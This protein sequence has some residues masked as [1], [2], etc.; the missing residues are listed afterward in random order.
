MAIKQNLLLLICLSIAGAAMLFAGEG[1]R[2]DGSATRPSEPRAGRDDR[3]AESLGWK[4]GLQAWTYRKLTLFETIDK[5]E[6]LGIRYLEMYPGQRL[7][8]E[9]D[10][11]AGHDMSSEHREAL[12]KKLKEADVT[13]VSYGVVG[14]S[15]DEKA[16][17]RVF[18]FAKEMGITTITSEPPFDAF[19][20]IEKLVK[21]YDIR[22]AIHNHPKP[23]RYWSP[24]IV[25]K[26]VKDHDERI[27]G[28][29]DTGHWMRSDVNP[30]EGLEKL[31]GRVLSLHL[32]QAAKLGERRVRDV[33][34]GEGKP[35]WIR[36]IMQQ[37]HE[38][39]YRGQWIIEY[40]HI[41]DRLDADVATCIRY[42]DEVAKQIASQ[43]DPKP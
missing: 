31:K 39:G 4:L 20:T 37:M 22:V 5:A 34:F 6:A 33:P 3:A 14:L 23:N 8:P 41:S 30:V 26:Q 9:L 32:K 16:S 35:D 36:P 12:R 42:F 11:R 43:A 27:G 7:S 40:E 29:P 28:G 1:A 17:R 21:E 24:D 19:D 18:D 25:L 2:G 38:Q 10:V 15:A 13:L